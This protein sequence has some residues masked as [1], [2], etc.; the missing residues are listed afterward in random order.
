MARPASW[1]QQLL[2]CWPLETSLV[3]WTFGGDATVPADYALTTTTTTTQCACNQMTTVL[4]L[5]MEDLLY[6]W[7]CN[8]YRTIFPT[9]FVH[10]H[11]VCLI[12]TSQQVE[13]CCS[14]KS[15]SQ[16]TTLKKFTFRDRPNLEALWKKGRLS[17]KRMY[18]LSSIMQCPSVLW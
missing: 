15:R 3:T 11:L 1:W 8:W 7:R 16:L 18:I 14:W 4:Q 6:L 17:K 5:Q 12:S 2:A 13:C 10:F 9:H